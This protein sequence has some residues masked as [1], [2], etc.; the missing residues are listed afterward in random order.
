MAFFFSNMTVTT[1]A[2]IIIIFLM[3]NENVSFN[4]VIW[5]KTHEKFIPIS[6][7]KEFH[8]L[9]LKLITKIRDAEKHN[10]QNEKL[11][12]VYF[13]V[14]KYKQ[15]MFYVSTQILNQFLI[16]GKRYI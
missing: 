16:I 9:Y 14:I 10:F 12:F 13:D 3:I 5:D 6:S 8:I 2:L 11:H 7:I 15:L 1:T 4:S